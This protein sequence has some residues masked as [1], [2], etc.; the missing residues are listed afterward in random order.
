MKIIPEMTF[1]EE[2]IIEK[3]EDVH[4]P[5]VQRLMTLGLIEGSTIK[6]ISSVSSSIEIEIYGSKLALNTDCASH[7]IVETKSS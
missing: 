3:I 5:C 1:N 4:L 6:Y 7:F 2:G